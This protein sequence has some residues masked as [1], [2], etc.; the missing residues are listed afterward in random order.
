MYLLHRKKIVIYANISLLLSYSKIIV[1]NRSSTYPDQMVDQHLEMTSTALN[2]SGDLGP[3]SILALR[4]ALSNKILRKLSE[5][6]ALPL[7]IKEKI[8]VKKKVIQKAS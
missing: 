7:T 5:M 3:Y 1:A 4:V 2:T 8:I 6:W